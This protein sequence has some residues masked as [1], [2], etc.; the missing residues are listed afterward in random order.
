[1]VVSSNTH[2]LSD[3]QRRYTRFIDIK[4]NSNYVFSRDSKNVENTELK[5]VEAYKRTWNCISINRI[6]VAIVCIHQLEVFEFD[7][8]KDKYFYDTK[9]VQYCQTSEER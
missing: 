1:M 8:N 5:D 7:T 3:V 6:H 2:F 4:E 9:H